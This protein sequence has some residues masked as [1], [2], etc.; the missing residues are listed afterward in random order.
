MADRQDAAAQSS[1]E[2]SAVQPT[3]SLETGCASFH[4]AGTQALSVTVL[5]SRAIGPAK[6]EAPSCKTRAGI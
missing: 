2:V 5:I 4:S 6:T 3:V 1:R